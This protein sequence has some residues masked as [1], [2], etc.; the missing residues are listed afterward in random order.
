MKLS[1]T[2]ILGQEVAVLLNEFKNAGSY[3]INF[4]ASQIA[5]GLYI[6]KIEADGIIISKKM[7]LLK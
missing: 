4:D 7:T 2:N 5:S 6:Y 1:V 3:D